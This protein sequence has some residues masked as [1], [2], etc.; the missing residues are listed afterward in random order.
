M[1][2]RS[3]VTLSGHH[4][5]SFDADTSW[6]RRRR[7]GAQHLGATPGKCILALP[8]PWFRSEA[9]MAGG[10][11]IDAWLTLPSPQAAFEGR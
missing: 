9:A 11:L 8:Y 5:F 7:V 3:A 2:G 6:E 10:V 4:F 1:N